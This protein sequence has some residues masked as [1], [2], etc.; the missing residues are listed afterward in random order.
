[1]FRIIKKKKYAVK[2]NDSTL[3]M[4]NKKQF[5]TDYFKHISEPKKVL[6]KQLITDYFKP[7]NKS[8]LSQTKITAYFKPD[9]NLSSR[10]STD[11]SKITSY[12]TKQSK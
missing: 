12:F 2:F 4:E 7:K 9:M 8:T 6:H 3:N 10:L 5:I 11:K 1:M